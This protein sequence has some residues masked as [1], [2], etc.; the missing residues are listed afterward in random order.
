[1]LDP[2]HEIRQ[3]L[4]RFDSQQSANNQVQMLSNKHVPEVCTEA[5][6]ADEVDQ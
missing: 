4:H 1:M 6:E 2:A 5:D 3:V